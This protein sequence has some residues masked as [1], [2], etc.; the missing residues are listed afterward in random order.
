MKE[1]VF[2]EA[3]ELPLKSLIPVLKFAVYFTDLGRLDEGVNM[4]VVDFVSEKVMLSVLSTLPDT[5]LPEL[6]N[7]VMVLLVMVELS[8]NSEKV[9]DMVEKMVVALSAGEVEVTFGA[10]VS[11][12]NEVNLISLPSLLSESVIK[13]EQFE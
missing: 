1:I 8:I 2:K 10:P 6:S 7:N 5:E 13:I 12:V 4:A 9:A 11:T 3:K